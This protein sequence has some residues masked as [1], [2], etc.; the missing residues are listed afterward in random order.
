[1][2][3]LLEVPEGTPG[4]REAGPHEGHTV[5]ACLVCPTPQFSNLLA[6]NLSLSDRQRVYPSTTLCENCVSY[7]CF[8]DAE[9]T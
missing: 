9:T 1:M 8:T 7:F 3:I 2:V 5:T 6:L 4:A